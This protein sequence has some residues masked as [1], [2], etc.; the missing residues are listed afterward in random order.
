M[1]NDPAFAQQGT[2]LQQM[3]D[4][5]QGGSA[6]FNAL[7]QQVNARIDQAITNPASIPKATP[8]SGDDAPPV[9]PGV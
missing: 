1:L 7:Q 8:P 4:K 3:A 6:Q 9:V 2:Q 5:G